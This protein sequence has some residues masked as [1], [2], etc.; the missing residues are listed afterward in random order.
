MISLTFFVTPD[1]FGEFGIVD[2]GVAVVLNLIDSFVAVYFLLA[3]GVGTV[4]FQQQV[5]GPLLK[6]WVNAIHHLPCVGPVHVLIACYH[7][8]ICAREVALVFSGR[9]KHVRRTAA[10]YAGSYTG[11]AVIECRGGSRCNL[12]EGIVAL[13]LIGFCLGRIEMVE[14]DVGGYA[15]RTAP[16]A[17]GQGVLA[18]HVGAELDCGEHIHVGIH[19]PPIVGAGTDICGGGATASG[20]IFGQ[21]VIA[22]Y[23]CVRIDN[24]IESRFQRAT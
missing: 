24:L 22:R 5:D 3:H 14:I 6:R 18:V 8:E 12:A 13:G 20:E 1:V 15:G 23:L 9:F 17:F 11:Y 19:I 16:P 7:I 2:E 10:V 4:P 21:G